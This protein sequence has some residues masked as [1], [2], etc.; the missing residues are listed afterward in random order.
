MN[1]ASACWTGWCAGTYGS[2]M[3]NFLD[4]QTFCSCGTGERLSELYELPA[5]SR[6]SPHTSAPASPPMMGINR[7]KGFGKD[8]REMSE[9]NRKIGTRSREQAKQ[10]KKLGSEQDITKG[11]T[12]YCQFPPKKYMKQAQSE[13]AY[14]Y[15]D[16]SYVF[17][18]S[19]TG[20][21]SLVF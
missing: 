10:P 17:R 18:S 7:Q 3:P 9:E 21:P 2:L 16:G 15:R 14:W 12:R 19:G 11:T 13:A 8:K 4:A 20:F 6:N 5:G 1:I